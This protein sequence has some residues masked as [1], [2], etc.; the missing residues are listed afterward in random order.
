MLNIKQ[1]CILAKFKFLLIKTINSK[2]KCKNQN[3]GILR[4]VI[5]GEVNLYI[6]CDVVMISYNI[7]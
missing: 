5:D 3:L 2:D 1:A 4:G 7:D 6:F